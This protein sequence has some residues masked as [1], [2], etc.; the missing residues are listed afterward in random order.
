M[1]RI[2]LY[3]LIQ[4]LIVAWAWQVVWN[5]WYYTSSLNL[6]SSLGLV[7]LTTLSADI[8]PRAILNTTM[9]SIFE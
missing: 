8:E 7:A 3:S 5:Q 1:G 9:P 4:R 6:G 2:W